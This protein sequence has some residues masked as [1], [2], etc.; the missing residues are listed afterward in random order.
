M[1]SPCEAGRRFRRHV[2]SSALGAIVLAASLL[3]TPAAVADEETHCV[4]NVL[5]VLLDGEFVV[6]DPVCFGTFAE[7]M[8]YLGAGDLG[9]QSGPELFAE[10]PRLD[11]RFARG[12]A[13]SRSDAEATPTPQG[14]YSSIIGIHFKGR[15]GSGSSVSISG[16]NCSGG[17]WNASSS[18]RNVI[19]SSYNGCVRLAHYSQPNISGSRYD[20][21]GVG[22]TD[23]IY[24]SMDNNTESVRYL[25]S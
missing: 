10:Q 12:T 14:G 17:Y 1:L 25:S 18:W 16:S 5:D 7:A 15:G 4:I 21:Y 6:S 11:G 23:S 2:R 3:V 22:Q 24:G 9:I 8:E 19:S 20:T 13:V